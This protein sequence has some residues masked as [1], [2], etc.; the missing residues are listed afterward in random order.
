MGNAKI[1]IFYFTLQLFNYFVQLFAFT[2]PSYRICK[3]TADDYIKCESQTTSCERNRLKK[4]I[5]YAA[6]LG[7]GT[8]LKSLGFAFVKNS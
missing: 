4:L 1:T 6:R 2:L 5:L 7:F 8:L 3:N